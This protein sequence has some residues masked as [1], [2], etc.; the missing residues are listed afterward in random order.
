MTEPED[1]E[2]RRIELDR[3]LGTHPYQTQERIIGENYQNPI[4]EDKGELG[5]VVFEMSYIHSQMHSDYDSAENTA[6]SDLED[7][8]LRKML[9]SPLFVRGR[10]DHDSSRKPTASGEPEAVIIQKRGASAQRTQAAHSKRESL[11]S[12]GNQ[13]EGSILKFADPSNWGRYLLEGN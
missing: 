7:G 12:P 11:M 3:N 9:A 10:E 6:D 8:E 5:T 4:A 1:L 2:P 13:L